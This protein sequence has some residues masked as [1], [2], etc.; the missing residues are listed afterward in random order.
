M[1]EGLKNSTKKTARWAIAALKHIACSNLSRR[2]E[3]AKTSKLK[4]LED[5]PDFQELR[6]LTGYS[7]EQEKKDEVRLAKRLTKLR[8]KLKKGWTLQLWRNTTPHNMWLESANGKSTYNLDGDERVL[9]RE[10]KKHCKLKEKK[11]TVQY[12][13]MFSRRFH[14]SDEGQA[15]HEIWEYDPKKDIE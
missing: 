12:P 3:V 15:Q 5:D 10:L 14:P 7:I 6:K 9:F 8:A 13:A 11:G 2:G 4:S 1:S